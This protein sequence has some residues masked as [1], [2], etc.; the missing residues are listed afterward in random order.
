MLSALA[1]PK[2]TVPG[3]LNFDHAVVIVPEPEAVPFKV[4]EAGNVIV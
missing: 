2:V 1:L 3:P 4:A